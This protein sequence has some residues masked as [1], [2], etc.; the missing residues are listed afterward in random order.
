MEIYKELHKAPGVVDVLDVRIL[1]KEGGDYSDTSYDFAA[2][3]ST[4]GRYLNSKIDTV[5]ELKYPSADIQG[6]VT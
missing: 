3:L 1:Q 4:D 5:F 6:S 2:N